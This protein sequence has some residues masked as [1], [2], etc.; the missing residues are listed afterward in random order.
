MKDVVQKSR[1][2]AL[3]VMMVA[4]TV[5][6]AEKFL[7]TE[8]LAFDN[9]Q[10]DYGVAEYLG[11]MSVKPE[12]ISFLIFDPEL[13]HSH[14]DLT[15]DFE[16]GDLHCS[17]FARPWNEERPRQKW[18]A[19][20][21]RGLIA[22][23]KHHDVASY[24]SFFDM[25]PGKGNGWLKL[26]K[27]TRKDVTWF[28]RHPEVGY[29]MKDGSRAKNVNPVE[30]F[31]DGTDYADFFVP[32]MVRFLAD[33]GFA[34]LHACDGFGHPRFS[35]DELDYSHLF[36]EAT[37]RV[38][39]CRAHAVRHAAFIAKLA[40]ALHAKG[41]KLYANTSWT[42]DPFEALYRYGVDYRLMGNAGLDGFVAE[43]SATVLELEGWRFS[44]VSALD[45]C[46]AAFLLTGA[47]VDTPVVHLACVKDGM[48]QYNSLRDAPQRMTAEVVSLGNLLRGDRLLAPD[49]FWC[50]ADGIA[51]EEWHRLDETWNLAKTPKRADGV[52]VV[53][54]SRAM[55]AELDAYVRE[56]YPSAYTLLAHLVKAGAVV[57][58]SVTVQEALADANMPLLVLNPGRFP[59]DELAA[60][61]NRAASVVSFGYGA[62]GCTFGAKPSASDAD[63]WLKPLPFRVFDPQALAAAVAAIN[64]VSPVFPGE[65][66]RD[67]RLASYVTV[68]DSRLVFAI[69]DR[70]TY[71]NARMS[72]RGPVVEAKAL[73]ASPSLPVIVRPLTDGLASLEAKIP[74]AGVVVLRV[75]GRH[76][77]ALDHGVTTE[78]LER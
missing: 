36:P 68:D 45:S 58:S 33:Y 71:L 25:A 39:L 38:A 75:E 42:R 72:V 61:T 18:T 17:Y 9:T 67:L 77:F 40:A 66:M 76:V 69:N 26:F 21:F 53:F 28:D 11:R 54:S 65:G 31:A 7:W 74:P 35:L 1:A 24:L 14:T 60:L 55:D 73:T 8:L 59:S 34:G 48:E 63:S 44:A 52:R 51:H 16:I 64:D 6:A 46:R 27:A 70:A 78:G 3:V 32:Q 41:L 62:P 50:L 20:Q 49:V 19:W 23:L 43:A 29:R 13:F 47:A 30:Q 22:E 15:R 12:G 5:S 37:D 2:L 56:G 4:G 10:A 57:N